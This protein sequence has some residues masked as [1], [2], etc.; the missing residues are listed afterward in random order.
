MSFSCLFSRGWVE[1]DTIAFR[2]SLM[3]EVEQLPSDTSRLSVLLNAAY[4]H[5]FPPYNVFFARHLYN[6]ARKQHNT[7]YENLGAYYL[8]LCYDKKHDLD[9]LIY[10]VNRLQ[11]LASK[12]GKYDYYLEEKAAIS[13]ALASK[14][15]NEKAIFVAKEV[16][17]ES[18]KRKS[19]NGIVAAYNSWGCAYSSIN[20]NEEALTILLKGYHACNR[21]TKLSLHIDVLSRLVKQY[22]NKFKSDSVLFYLKKMDELL[23]AAVVREPKTLDNWRDVLVDCQTRYVRFYMNKK[24]FSKTAEYLEK[25]KTLLTSEVD[26]VYW[27]NIQLMELQYYGAIK[28][29]DKAIA[30]IDQVAPFVEASHIDV[31]EVLIYY[32][33]LML[34]NKED[35]DGGINTLKYLLHKQDSLGVA[36]STSQLEQM[37]ESYHIDE[38]LIEKQKIANLNYLRAIIVLIVLLVLMALFYLYTKYLSRRIALAE[39]AAAKAAELSRADNQAKERLKLEISHDIRTPLNAVVGFAEILADT[40][41]MEEE[42][43]ETYNK[44][45]QENATQLLDYVNNILELSRLESG[46]IKYVEQKYD[47]ISLLREVVEQANKNK[48]NCVHVELHVETEKQIVN[49][50]ISRLRLLF[51][52]LT[53]STVDTEF[54][55]SNIIVKRVGEK[56][57]LMVTVINTPLAKERFE[58]KTAMI[59]NEINTHFIHYF[60]GYYKVDEQAKQ[61]PTVTFTYPYD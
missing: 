32:R 22:A 21:N 28:E 11:V 49:T 7:Y 57:F 53:T 24:N 58:N 9:S 34:K 60:G 31:F 29:Y 46:K 17:K 3:R 15:M 61:G 19:N 37:K 50:D 5:Q 12:I 8:S 48:D 42:G 10:W 47:F 51:D 38:L 23:N 4:L 14:K 6:E 40:E 43:K 35:W 39:K 27:L 41:N 13:R 26:S 33:A 52:S 59:R 1:D 44:I 54:Y 20:L 16:L 25:A 36:F 30:L 45:I 55:H 18:E 56:S 2:D